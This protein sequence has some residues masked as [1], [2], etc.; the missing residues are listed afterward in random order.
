MIKKRSRPA[1]VRER[2]TEDEAAAATPVDAAGEPENAEG[3]GEAA[4]ESVWRATRWNT[5]TDP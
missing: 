4:L 3:A 5:T 1:T 2:A